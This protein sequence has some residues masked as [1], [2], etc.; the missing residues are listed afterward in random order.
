MS[1]ELRLICKWLYVDEDSHDQTNATE[2]SLKERNNTVQDESTDGAAGCESRAELPMPKK[3]VVSPA[4]RDESPKPLRRKRKPWS[5]I[6]E[7]TLRKGVKKYGAGNWK[8]ILNM[9][10]DI[11]DDR[12]AVDLKDK[13]RNLIV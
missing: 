13:W 12:T 4:K 10:S 6:E 11:F 1:L 5:N 7:D 2:A 3:S 9:Y 8:F